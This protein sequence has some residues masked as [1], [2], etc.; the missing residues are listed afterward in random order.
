MDFKKL[1]ADRTP[2]TVTPEKATE[3]KA[4]AVADCNKGWFQ[5]A[6]RDLSSGTIYEVGIEY[7]WIRFADGVGNKVGWGDIVV[8]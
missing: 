1:M 2:V 6:Y 8:L 5:S 4:E 7:C 3:I